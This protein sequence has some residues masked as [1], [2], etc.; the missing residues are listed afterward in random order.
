MYVDLYMYIPLDLLRTAA[1]IQAWLPIS[2]LCQTRIA[3]STECCAECGEQSLV[4]SQIWAFCGCFWSTPQALSYYSPKASRQL[5][6]A[7]RF[8]RQ[9][10]MSCASSFCI[11]FRKA[12]TRVLAA[13]DP[14][15]N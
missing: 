2:H 15:N 5:L 3:F 12:D 4:R 7:T 6:W 9:K 10:F 13:K 8:L 1:V 11:L 14:I